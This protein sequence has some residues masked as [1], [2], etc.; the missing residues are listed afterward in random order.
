MYCTQSDIEKEVTSEKL[1]ELTDD[2]NSG[3]VVVANV[4]DAITKADSLIDGY[5][6]GRYA[7]P[8]ATVPAL[9]KTLSVSLSI[10]YLYK[11]RGRISDLYQDQYDKDIKLLGMLAGGKVTLGV[12][13][14]SA[15]SPA[16]CAEMEAVDDT[17]RT[18]TKDTLGYF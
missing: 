12:D 9:I 3:A 5:C 13:A 2:A 17:D 4:T 11:R 7:V 15:D 6:N 16:D 1:I 14:A 18:F 10:Y 8:F